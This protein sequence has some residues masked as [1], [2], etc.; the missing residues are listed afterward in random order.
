MGFCYTCME[1]IEDGK[2]TKCPH[3]GADLDLGTVE[4]QFLPPGTELEGKFIV[5]KAIG[6]GG[7]GH[8]YIGWNK[9]L[10]SK[11]AIKEYYPR[12][13]CGRD[14]DGVTV[15]GAQGTGEE[16]FEN[17]LQQFLKEAR[18]V[19]ELQDIKG[20]VKVYS[21]FEA[22]GTGYIV[23]EYLEGMDVKTIL[24]QSGN[25]RDYEWCRRVILT[26]LYT[27]KD[28]HKRGVLHRDIAPDNIFITKEGIIKLIDFGAAIHATAD[29][30]STQ[31]EIILKSGYAP[32]EQYSRKTEQGPYTDLYAVAALFYRMLTGKK[33]APAN[34]RIR[35]EKIP[36]PSEL[37]VEIPEEAE[38]GIMV[39]LNV[40]P[41]HRLQSA[42]EFMEVLGGGDF[43]PVYEPEWILPAEK[44]EKGGFFMR[45]PVAAK[46][47]M[48]VAVLCIIGGGIAAIVMTTKEKNAVV[49][50]AGVV[51]SSAKM[52]RLEGTAFDE[53]SDKLKEAGIT[54][55][56]TK[57][58]KITYKYDKNTAVE[59]ILSQNISPGSPIGDE[60]L[61][62]V[63][64][65]SKHIAL[66]S[67]VGKTTKEAEAYFKQY[68]LSVTFAAP[69][70]NDAQSYGRVIAQ[71]P[72]AGEVVDL[73]TLKQINC[74]VSLGKKT[75][76]VISLAGFQGLTLKEVRDKIYKELAGR[77]SIKD[78]KEELNKL[79]N[80]HVKANSTKEYSSVAKDKVCAQ[81]PSEKTTNHN[82]RESTVTLTLSKGPK[83][84]PKP[85]PRPTPKPTKRPVVRATKRPS[86]K[87]SSTTTKKKKKKSSSSWSDDAW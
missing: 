35:N 46:A 3:C 44:K 48:L 2:Y 64:A 51:D 52:I 29:N 71:E 9:T 74:G 56:Q 36:T 20:V 7:F 33:P 39:C 55:D 12:Q 50:D 85:T 26:V 14:G 84:T 18:S 66:E 78:G 65:T 57:D 1:Q 49:T 59:E 34:E 4:K 86:S 5:G 54:L 69:V 80:E 32:I 67:V 72:A 79:V 38:L 25:K 31:T 53:M 15:A 23:M 42:E 24:K 61:E 62:I 82:I 6:S 83:P 10:L 37:G 17:G 27:L 28:V 22:N 68:G 16:R 77:A 81:N 19:A 63:V 8:T 21:V 75:D 43:E 40:K 45:L 76:Y 73:D 87:K 11:V 58:I 30:V 60:K 41:E 13:F 47:A 70:Y